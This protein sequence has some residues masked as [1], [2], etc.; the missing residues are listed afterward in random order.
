MRI[1]KRISGMAA[2][3]WSEE[4]TCYFADHP[5]QGALITAVTMIAPFLMIGLLARWLLLS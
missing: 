5:T 4:A 3:L 2:W 1:L